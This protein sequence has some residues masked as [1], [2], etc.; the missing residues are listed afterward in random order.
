MKFLVNR[1]LATRISIIMTAII[2]AGMILLWF[3]VSSRAASMVKSNITNQMT[4]AVESRASI[5]D[6]YVLS[7]EEYMT[8]FALGGE[9]RA[10]LLNPDDPELLAQ[11]QKYTED[12]AAVKGVFEGLYIATPETHVLTHTSQ[13]A[14]GMTTRRGIR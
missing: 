10:L 8:A 5:I 2:F 12:F 1:K 9:V 7:A 4:D 14:I 3:V 6:A 13:G 11:A